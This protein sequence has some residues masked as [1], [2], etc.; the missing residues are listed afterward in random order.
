MHGSQKLV[1][2]LSQVADF[3]CIIDT[4]SSFVT[5]S[6]YIEDLVD[7]TRCELLRKFKEGFHTPRLVLLEVI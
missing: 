5:A 4:L 1:H 2:M 6:C 7:L 3:D